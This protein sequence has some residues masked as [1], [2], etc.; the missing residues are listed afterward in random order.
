MP[1]QTHVNT[2]FEN[3]DSDRSKKVNEV[4]KV[5]DKIPL[6]YESIYAYSPNPNKLR[7]PDGKIV[8]FIIA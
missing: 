6:N 7:K 8:N 1:F 5:E 4:V 3:K 2:V